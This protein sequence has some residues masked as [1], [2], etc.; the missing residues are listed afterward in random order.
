MKKFLI[1]SLCIL[2]VI[3]AGVAFWF[4]SITIPLAEVA[5]IQIVDGDKGETFSVT[6]E[7]YVTYVCGFM[8]RLVLTPHRED[9][10]DRVY[11]LTF[12]DE[13]GNSIAEVSLRGHG[14]V[15]TETGT[16]AAD[17]SE[18]VHNMDGLKQ[19]Y[20][21]RMRG[22]VLFLLIIA[23]LILVVLSSLPAAMGYV[24]EMIVCANT[25]VFA[26][27]LIPFL[28]FGA[29]AA[30]DRSC[31]ILFDIVEFAFLML[32]NTWAADLVYPIILLFML[33]GWRQGSKMWKEAHPA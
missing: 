16:Y 14:T 33:L 20:D 11:T 4:A 12:L 19:G 2:L 9:D 21:V 32:D 6:Q 22:N 25:G 5:S 24:A 18:L 27:R 28:V 30:L 26:H 1:I 17:V 29:L 15:I 10:G 3:G 13:A 8:N 7:K 31:G 23:F